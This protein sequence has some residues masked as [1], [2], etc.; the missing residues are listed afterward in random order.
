MAV[1]TRL[2]FLKYFYLLHNLYYSKSQLVAPTR[3]CSRENVLQLF[4]LW[5]VLNV[6]QALDASRII[7]RSM[8]TTSIGLKSRYAL[9][10]EN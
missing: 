10:L 1:L 9:T 2:T 8:C 6:S 3:S 5:S 7:Q 4:L